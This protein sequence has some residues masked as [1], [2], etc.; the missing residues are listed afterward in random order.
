MG[1]PAEYKD[2]DFAGV[3]HTIPPVSSMLP[4]PRTSKASQECVGG[5]ENKRNN[6]T[7]DRPA[8]PDGGQ[9]GQQGSRAPIKIVDGRPWSPSVYRN[10]RQIGLTLDEAWKKAFIKVSHF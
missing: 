1:I 7:Y 4:I 5:R 2:K 3:I 8:E 6:L 10:M 9:L